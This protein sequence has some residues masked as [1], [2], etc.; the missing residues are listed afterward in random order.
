MKIVG[1]A[2][3]LLASAIAMMAIA[4]DWGEPIM[5]ESLELHSIFKSF[6]TYEN[7][8]GVGDAPQVIDEEDSFL[9]LKDDADFD[10]DR[11]FRKSDTL[12]GTSVTFNLEDGT[13]LD[14]YRSPLELASIKAIRI[15]NLSTTTGNSLSISGDWFL[16]AFG[17]T[18]NLTIPEGAA[19]VFETPRLG[20]IVIATTQDQLT[21]DSGVNVV[22]YKLELIGLTQ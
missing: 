3:G 12:A 2:T 16:A 7:S 22:A 9:Y 8:S 10:A 18:P 17:V 21:I 4:Q 15:I 1:I 14:I 5:A 19:F 11:Y 6:G 20:L 13:M